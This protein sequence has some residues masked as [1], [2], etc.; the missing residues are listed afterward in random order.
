[1]HEKQECRH[2]ISRNSERS[3]KKDVVLRNKNNRNCDVVLYQSE[4]N[5]KYNVVLC[6]SEAYRRVSALHKRLQFRCGKL[7]T[8]GVKQL[9]KRDES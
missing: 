4:N 9:R 2:Y 5:M 8:N 1:M 7:G 3:K 6:Q